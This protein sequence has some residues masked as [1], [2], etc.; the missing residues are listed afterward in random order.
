[1]FASASRPIF[2]ALL[3]ALL[4]LFPQAAAKAGKKEGG[5]IGFV[6][7]TPNFQLDVTID[8]KRTQTLYPGKVGRLTLE[9]D[10]PAGE[11]EAGELAPRRL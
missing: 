9:D 7:D 1:M 2:R 8:G 3:I 4:L 10:S 11:H 5:K 6:N